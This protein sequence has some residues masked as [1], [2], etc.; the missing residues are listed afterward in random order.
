MA[1][2]FALTFVL[3]GDLLESI[4]SPTA[5]T[6]RWEGM[7]TTAW[8]IAIAMLVADLALPIPSTAILA[9]L[10]TTYGPWIGA[11][12]GTIGCT[13]GALVGYGIARTGSRMIDR[14]VTPTHRNQL[15]AYFQRWGAWT[16]VATRA[17][18]IVPEVLSVLA[19]LA[20]MPLTRF[21]L[22]ILVGSLPISLFYA[23]VG[24]TMQQTPVYGIAISALVPVL[25]WPLVAWTLRPP[26]FRACSKTDPP[27]Y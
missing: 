5:L 11:L 24:Y 16:L 3:W 26:S 17:L 19:G 2:I 13:L 25:L 4:C 7:R 14:I 12:I 8:I 22:A 21:T 9:A 20:S 18:P 1:T 6:D 15:A 27:A 23:S 10:G